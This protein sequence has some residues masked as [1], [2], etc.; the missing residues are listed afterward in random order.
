MLAARKR[1]LRRKVFNRCHGLCG[2]CSKPVRFSRFELDHIVPLYRGGH[3]VVSNLQIAHSRCNA[4]KWI[5]RGPYPGG[6]KL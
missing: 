5:G 6:W 1:A 4:R 3:D 2:I